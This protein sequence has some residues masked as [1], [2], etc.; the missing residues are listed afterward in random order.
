MSRSLE[1]L[2]IQV[3]IFRIKPLS[4]NDK[5]IFLH[6]LLKDF[7]IEERITLLMDKAPISDYVEVRQFP[8]CEPMSSEDILR[9]AKKANKRSKR[10]ILRMIFKDLPST[11]IADC[12]VA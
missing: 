8:K 9:H 4:D 10:I 2:Y 1:T 12:L 7:T 6:S 5:K 3:L 11:A